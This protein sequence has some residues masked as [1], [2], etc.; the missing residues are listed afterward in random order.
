[1][2]SMQARQ[3]VVSTEADLK[4]MSWV[5]PLATAS[6]FEVLTGRASVRREATEW[7]VTADTGDKLVVNIW[8]ASAAR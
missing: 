3:L 1:H 5:F 8:S 2:L 4:D 7:V 6:R